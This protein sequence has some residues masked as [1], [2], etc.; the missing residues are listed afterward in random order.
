MNNMNLRQEIS[1]LKYIKIKPYGFSA[2]NN[3]RALNTNNTRSFAMEENKEIWK[4]VKENPL[5]YEVS[6][7][8]RVRSWNTAKT[9]A[10]PTGEVP[11]IMR[12]SFDSSGYRAV[13]IKV[14]DDYQQIKVHRL[15]AEAFLKNPHNK[16]EVNHKD[17]NPLNN[18]LDNIEWATS[19]ENTLH[20]Y[21]N[22]LQK[23]GED[24][25]SA[26][27]TE[28]EAIEIINAYKIGVFTQRELAEAYGVS[29]STIKDLL[30]GR[31]WAHLGIQDNIRQ[32]SDRVCQYD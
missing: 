12:G 11:Y 3:R 6:N 9:K 24:F 20:S 25:Y 14:G 16:L 27:L 22:G 4:P 21:E 32:R 28:N 13:K 7:K 5:V 26:K 8:G 23:R 17:G 19:S 2:K 31:N 30:S 29:I 18:E 15:V 1:I 10:N